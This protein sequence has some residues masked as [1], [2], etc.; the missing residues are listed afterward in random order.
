MRSP[1]KIATAGKHCIFY[2]ISFCAIIKTVNRPSMW[3]RLGK[4]CQI[5]EL[6]EISWGP[7]GV[8]GVPIGDYGD[9]I[10]ALVINPHAMA[11]KCEVHEH[12]RP[13]F[14][15]GEDSSRNHL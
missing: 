9:E 15:Q 14:A 7:L 6:V 13:S 10:L 1:V 4:W 11:T 2:S 3:M 8:E 5:L 12:S